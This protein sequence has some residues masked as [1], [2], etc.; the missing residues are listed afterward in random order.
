MTEARD[1]GNT[2][3]DHLRFVRGRIDAACERS[4]R[5]PEEVTLIAVSK[6]KPFSDIMEARAAGVIHFGENYV[7]ELMQKQE[8]FAAGGET[9][10]I[11]W[12]MI[13]H[14]QRNK[15][16]Y[17]IGR[18]ALIHSVDSVPLAEQIEKEAAKK[19]QTVRILLEVNAARE[20]SKWGFDFQSVFPAA[21]EISAFPHVRVLGLMTSAPYT[22][23][24]ETNRLYFR[25]LSACAR[26][27]AAAK[28]LSVSDS[29]FRGPVLSMGMSGDYEVAVEEGATMVRVGTGI[30]GRRQYA[31][32]ES[33]EQP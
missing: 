8:Q 28:L 13:G 27:M 15:V 32:P 16:K 18:T 31:A 11:Q 7:Q 20:E 25:D 22:E 33:G 26:E 9:G 17:L 24:P 14:L 4:G 1:T 19:G 3:A 21:G 29:N 30:F 2:I 23:D 12:H 6:T 5:S 10:P